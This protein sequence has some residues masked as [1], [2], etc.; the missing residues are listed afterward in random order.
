MLARPVARLHR[1]I[2][3]PHPHPHT[4][5]CPAGTYSASGST[6]CIAAPKGTYTPSGAFAPISCPKGS[7]GDATRLTACKTCPPGYFC[8]VTGIK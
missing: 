8:P 4:Q 3:P 1:C 6:T 2:T 5:A 7:Y